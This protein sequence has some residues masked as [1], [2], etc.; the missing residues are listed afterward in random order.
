MGRL[1]PL[2]I[3]PANINGPICANSLNNILKIII[4][5]I[6]LRPRGINLTAFSIP[7][8]CPLNVKPL[9]PWILLPGSPLLK[10]TMLSL[11]SL[12]NF[13][14]WLIFYP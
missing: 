6:I 14:K 8:K 2:N 1:P 3:S 13:P 11:L 5:T 7:Y 4:Y 12:I 9:S 10:I